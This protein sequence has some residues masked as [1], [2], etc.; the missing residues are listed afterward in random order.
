LWYTVFLNSC[1]TKANN[2]DIRWQMKVW[3]RILSNLSQLSCSGWVNIL[4]IYVHKC[5]LLIEPHLH[6]F[7]IVKCYVGNDIF[8]YCL[9][10]LLGELPNAYSREGKFQGEKLFLE[11]LWFFF[12]FYFPSKLK[13]WWAEFAYKA[14]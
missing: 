6:L 1:T 3:R 7:M 12:H 2:K 5:A 4:S 14:T 10:K 9:D 11:I 13:P 8:L